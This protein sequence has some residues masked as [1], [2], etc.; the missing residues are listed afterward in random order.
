MERIIAEMQPVMDTY[1]YQTWSTLAALEAEKENNKWP[2]KKQQ[3][4][5]KNNRC[6]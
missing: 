5:L 4:Q 2:V 1:R 3:W 6:G